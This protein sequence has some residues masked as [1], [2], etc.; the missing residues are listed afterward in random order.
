MLGRSRGRNPQRGRGKGVPYQ[1]GITYEDFQKFMEYQRMSQLAINED[2]EAGSSDNSDPPQKITRTDEGREETWT[3][4]KGKGQPIPMKKLT[5]PRIIE[6]TKQIL[7]PPGFCKEEYSQKNVVGKVF[8]RSCPHAEQ[9]P[10]GSIR[11]EFNRE[12]LLIADNLW[13]NSNNSRIIEFKQAIIA[14]LRQMRTSRILIAEEKSNVNQYAR[15]L[16]NNTG[17]I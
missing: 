11:K 6:D 16:I 14:S 9:F 1:K 8:L 4:V 10:I 15:E 7:Y 17:I 3:R 5:F 12:E 13:K 2:S